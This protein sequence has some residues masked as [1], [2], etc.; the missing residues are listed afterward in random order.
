L[1][2][3]KGIV[4]QYGGAFTG[5]GPTFTSTFTKKWGW[6]PTLY[7]LAKEDITRMDQI[8]ELPINVVLQHLAF[9]NDYASEL[10]RLQ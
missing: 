9:L 4:D 1:D 10:K 8:T 6:Y 2:Y 5:S 7:A 3:K